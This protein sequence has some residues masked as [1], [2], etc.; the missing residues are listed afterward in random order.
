MSG[1]GVLKTPDLGLSIGASPNPVKAGRTVTYT[2]TVKNFGLGSAAGVVV[3]DVLPSGGQFV[4]AQT[5]QG[6]CTA[7]AL[8]QTGTVICSQGSL[9]SGSTSTVQIVAKI[10]AP[11][12]GTVSDTASATTTGTD[13]N[14]ANNSA[15]ASVVVK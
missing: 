8:G 4:S 7:P 11:K 2:V 12:K 3:T 9:G 15:M 6:T 1:T 5:S 13:L 10:V 14:P